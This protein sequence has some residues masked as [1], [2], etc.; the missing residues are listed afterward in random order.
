MAKQLAKRSRET[1]VSFGPVDAD[2]YVEVTY[3]G[4][5][6]GWHYHPSLGNIKLLTDERLH[7][8]TIIHN[9]ENRA[10]INFVKISTGNHVLRQEVNPYEH[11]YVDDWVVDN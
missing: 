8:C 2:G 10:M 7:E 1:T 11:R 9:F 5:K 3:N 4:K 6:Y